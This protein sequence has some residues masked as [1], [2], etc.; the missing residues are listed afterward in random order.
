YGVNFSVN[1]SANR[2]KI[3]S[4]GALEDFGQS[5][6]WASTQIGN[7]YVVRIGE[8]VG[9]MYGFQNDGRYEVSDFDYDASTGA[10]TLR[11]DVVD[12]NAIVGEVMPGTL[13]LKDITGD[14]IVD[15]N[16]N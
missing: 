13:K 16:D 9:I 3:N 8:P 7:D 15:V 11:P 14:G 4:L 6:G 5:T 2:N 1:V 12:N 10:Y